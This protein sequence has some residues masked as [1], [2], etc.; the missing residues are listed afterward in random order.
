MVAGLLVVAV[1]LGFLNYLAPAGR[2]TVI[3]TIVEVTPNVAGQVTEINIQPNQ[4]VKAGTVLFRI[5]PVPLDA[6]VR[7][8]E[9]RFKLADQR[10]SEIKQLQE[11]GAGRQND[12]E[13]RQAEA[14]ELKAQL[15]AAKYDLDQ[16]TVRAPA[17][18]YV[19]VLA[20]NKGDRV[21]PLKSV[22]SFVSSADLQ[23]IGVF[24]QNGLK[25]IQPGARAQFSLASDPGRIYDTTSKALVAVSAKARSQYPARLR[26]SHR[27]R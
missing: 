22:M 1:F 2:V 25:A 11:R 19:T 3:A 10:L 14:D 20:L 18:G 21:T 27:F 13:Q 24:S 12:V 4:P 8:T 9:A 5:D 6:K 23:I 15:D 26:A 17:D 7:I 16:A